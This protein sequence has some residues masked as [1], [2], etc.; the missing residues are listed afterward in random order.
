MRGHF[1]NP[2]A[3][4]LIAEQGTRV[5]MKTCSRVRRA[6]FCQRPTTMDTLSAL[7]QDADDDV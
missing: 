7:T 5:E 1:E 6:E 2:L 4:S 3:I